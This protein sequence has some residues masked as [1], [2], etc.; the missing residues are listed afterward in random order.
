MTLHLRKKTR[1]KAQFYPS[2]EDKQSLTAP[3]VELKLQ[4][5]GPLNFQ[6]LKG[7]HR[8]LGAEEAV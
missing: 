5:L 3:Q 4:E 8:W 6:Q 1:K 7:T 2:N